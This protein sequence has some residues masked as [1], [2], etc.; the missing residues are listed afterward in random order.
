MVAIAHDRQTIG[1]GLGASEIACVLGMNP[2]RSPLALYEEKVGEREPFAGNDFTE[3]G[4]LVETPLLQWYERRLEAGL[5][6]IRPTESVYHPITSWARCTPDGLVIKWDAAAREAPAQ[7]GVQAKNASLWSG[8]RWDNGPPDEVQ[9]Q[10]QWE[11]FVTGLVRVDVIAALAGMP[12]QTWTVYRDGDIIA[13][14]FAAAERFWARVQSRTPPPVDHHEDWA[15]RFAKKLRGSASLVV[16]PGPVTD[17]YAKELRE[18]RTAER[19]IKERREKLENL[20]REQM[21]DAG[22]DAIDTADGL[23]T[24]REKAGS[25]SWKTAA[26]K[27]A[28]EFN[29]TDLSARV[30]ATRGE[31]TRSFNVP[32]SWGKETA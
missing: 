28:A 8:K 26:E 12:P 10:C 2:Y 1:P 21:A 18:A 30:E 29:V 15:A 25:V 3:W 7:W 4:L 13:D 14:L 19:I 5:T 9:L 24:W 16:P 27:L 22:A 32:R 23:I 20:I 17:G 6:L 11:M 31:P